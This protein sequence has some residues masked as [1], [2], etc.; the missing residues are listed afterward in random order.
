MLRS[1]IATILISLGTSFS[2]MS[3]TNVYHPLPENTIW[4]VDFS[5]A[6]HECMNQIY[7]HYYFEGDTTING[8]GYRR[9]MRSPILST[10]IGGGFY[11]GLPQNCNLHIM[12]TPS[13]YLGGYAGVIRDDTISNKVYGFR[14]GFDTSEVVLMDYNLD[15]GD[16][17]IFDWTVN[18]IDS[19]L[20]NGNYRKRWFYD[21][22]SKYFIQGIGTSLGL[23]EGYFNILAGSGPHCQLI[24]VKDTLASQII[25]DSGVLSELGCQKITA[26]SENE[27]LQGVS[28][29]PNP[30]TEELNVQIGEEPKEFVILDLKGRPLSIG[31]LDPVNSIIDLQDLSSGIYILKVEGYLPTRF[32]K[33]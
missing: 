14:P 24:C 30:V 16:T 2:L 7:Y 18:S 1:L 21:Q 5:A 20:I 3:Q 4:R 6:W 33:E 32:I 26:V 8:I 29:Y 19:I 11:Y 28:V 9:V 31:L 22:S 25:Y 12:I 27:L 13:D 17:V 15:V 10:F 23:L